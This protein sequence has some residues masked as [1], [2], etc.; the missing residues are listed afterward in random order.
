ME[1]YI[2]F[3]RA[4]G[5]I[6]YKAHGPDGSAAIQTIPDGYKLRMVST[7]VGLLDSLALDPLRLDVW[8]DVK[9]R[10]DATIN[11]GAETPSGRVDSDELSRS[12]INGAVMAAFLSNLAGQPF[13]VTWTMA[14][15]SVVSLNAEQ[16][17][18][19]GLAVMDHVNTAHERA[20][21]L[22]TAIEAAED[23][24][25]LLLVDVSAEQGWGGEGEA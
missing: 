2:V 12:N 15:N 20:R 14:D 3:E 23:V 7:P 10:R 16:M 17:I 8:A 11:G 4:T 21:T 13:T 6:E 9:V 18:G 5:T 24:A 19:V 22:R 25:S 1:N